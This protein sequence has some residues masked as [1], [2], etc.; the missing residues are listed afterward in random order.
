MSSA[1][2]KFSTNSEQQLGKIP[3]SVRFPLSQCLF[4]LELLASVWD[5]NTFG[6]VR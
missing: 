1:G 6:L 4:M 5:D 2:E 3:F